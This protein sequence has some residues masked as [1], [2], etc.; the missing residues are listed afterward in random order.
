MAVNVS[1]QIS[2]GGASASISTG[3]GGGGG[4]QSTPTGVNFWAPPGGVPACT[5]TGEFTEV[6]PIAQAISKC[7]ERLCVEQYAFDYAHCYCLPIKQQI[8]AKAYDGCIL[9]KMGLFVAPPYLILNPHLNQA[10]PSHIG[11]TAT[12]PQVAQKVTAGSQFAPST[13]EGMAKR[14]T[15]SQLVPKVA[16]TYMVPPEAPSKLPMYLLIGAA[17]IAVGATGYYLTRPK[18]S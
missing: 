10:L 16:Q 1:G 15:A 7:K 3:G 14:Y 5:K 18:K 12:G 2:S 9:A 8:G 4:G 11:L 6:L 13:I 17:V